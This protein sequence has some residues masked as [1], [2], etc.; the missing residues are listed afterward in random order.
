MQAQEVGEGCQM[1]ALTTAILGAWV[2]YLQRAACITHTRP[3]SVN[4]I[5]TAA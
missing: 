3:L 5:Y 1:L 2:R 4:R